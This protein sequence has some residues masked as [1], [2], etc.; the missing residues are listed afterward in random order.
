MFFFSSSHAP[1]PLL[2]RISSLCATPLPPGERQLPLF[3]RESDEDP[4]D[5]GYYP[6]K[7]ETIDSVDHPGYHSGSV[8]HHR[9][10][11]LAAISIS[12]L[13]WSCRFNRMGTRFGRPLQSLARRRG[14]Q[15]FAAVAIARGLHRLGVLRRRFAAVGAV[16]LTPRSPATVREVH[17]LCFTRR[18]A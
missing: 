8:H 18:L 5:A 11:T 10:Q 6:T 4:V 3:C 2:G 16:N 17:G 12:K 1:F 7:R 14:Q 15:W 13:P 9:R